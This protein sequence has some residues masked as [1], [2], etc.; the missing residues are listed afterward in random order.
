[1]KRKAMVVVTLVL[2]LAAFC[3]GQEP[4]PQIGPGQ[5][6]P[7]KPAQRPLTFTQRMKQ[8][9]ART[10]AT[11][12]DSRGAADLV[13]SIYPDPKGGKTTIV[14]VNDRRRN[15][16]GFY[17]YNFGNVKDAGNKEEIYRYLLNANDAISIGTFFVDSED[18][19]GY[20]YLVSN[21]AVA[22]QTSFDFVYFAM[23]A[24]SREHKLE[25]RKLL[26]LPPVNEEP[27]SKVKK[28]AEDKPPGEG[29]K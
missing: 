3:F 8:L 27:P 1:M 7:A 19:I 22:T 5:I 23:A 15:L 29:V 10:G 16:L 14:L 28:A 17:I 13:V 21:Q 25:I 12:D 20:K 2:N 11:I 24:V 18:D 26:G 9:L 6:G 4:A